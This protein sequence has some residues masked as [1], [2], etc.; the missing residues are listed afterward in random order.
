MQIS[1]GLGDGPGEAVD[2]FVNGPE[3]SFVISDNMSTPSLAGSRGVPRLPLA[4]PAQNV[5][6][7]RR[8]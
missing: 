2:S 7:R 6:R 5:R 4:D 3:R 8:V 1:W